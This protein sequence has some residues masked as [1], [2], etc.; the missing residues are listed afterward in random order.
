MRSGVAN[1]ICWPWTT[2]L[3]LKIPV[4]LLFTHCWIP[5][6]INPIQGGH[7]QGCSRM[8]GAKRPPSLISVTHI[9]QLWNLAQLYLTYRRS[10]KYINHVTQPMSS[11]DISIFSPEISKFCYIKKCRYRLH[12][13][14]WFL[15]LLIFLKD[16]LIKMIIIL[17]MSAKMAT[18]G[19]LKTMIFWNKGYGVIIPVHDVS[20][21]IL[22]HGSNDIVDVVTWPKF[23][24]SCVSMR[25]VIITSIL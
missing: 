16:F 19:L 21:K 1:L 6:S 22:S 4:H 7:F 17:M 15:I 5:L 13:D 10:K 14:A 23:G 20:N 2:N 12:F 9:L 24:N 25:G 3:F 18:P 8:G 11:A